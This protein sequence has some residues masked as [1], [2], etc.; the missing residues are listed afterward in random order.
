MTRN[1]DVTRESCPKCHGTGSERNGRFFFYGISLICC[2]ML[3]FFEW[4]PTPFLIQVVRNA[5][6]RLS[7][8]IWIGP[9]MVWM[10][11][12]VPMILGL[13]CICSWLRQGVCRVCY[14]RRKPRFSEE[15]MRAI[16]G[17]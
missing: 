15:T 8:P 1:Q 3:V 2:A 5:C 17:S 6:S 11:T 7:I 14:G 13:G 4:P 12:L 10:L 16:S 9:V